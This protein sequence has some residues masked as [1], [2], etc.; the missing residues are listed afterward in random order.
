MVPIDLRFHFPIFTA[1][2]AQEVGGVTP[3]ELVLQI[4]RRHIVPDVD[5]S[6]GHGRERRFTGVDILKIRCAKLMNNLGLPLSE[7]APLADIVAQ[8]AWQRIA[9]FD[10][11]HL[12]IAAYPVGRDQ[13][14]FTPLWDDQETGALPPAVQMLDVDALI[15]DTTKRLHAIIIGAKVPTFPAAIVSLPKLTGPADDY[16][17]RWSKADGRHVLVGLTPEETGEYISLRRIALI[18][19]G[20]HAHLSED[21]DEQRVRDKEREMELWTKHERAWERHV[22]RRGRNRIKQ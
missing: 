4:H 3:A 12:R 16:A 15:Q 17:K 2:Q 22:R 20:G 5:P 9:E 21:E 18:T 11:R 19:N 8:R 1:A 6:P 13:W 10:R 14:A 7:L